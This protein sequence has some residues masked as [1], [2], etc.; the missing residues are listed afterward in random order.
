MSDKIKPDGPTSPLSAKA[1][2]G[3][4]GE[5]S[6]KDEVRNLIAGLGWGIRWLGIS[7]AWG[8]CL[9]AFMVLIGHAIW[10]GQIANPG[11]YYG[12]IVVTGLLT[13]ILSIVRRRI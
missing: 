7:L 6:F 13:V 5:D 12:L 10:G 8:G 11:P 4:A 3:Q 9:F 1:E 2:T